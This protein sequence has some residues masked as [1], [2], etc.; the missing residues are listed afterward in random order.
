MPTFSSP[1]KNRLLAALGSLDWLRLQPFVERVDLP[2][3]QRIHQHGETVSHAYF[4]TTAVASTMHLTES[5]AC[6]ESAMVGN[7]GMLG[8]SLFM[9]G[10][11][12]FGSASVLSSGEAYRIP[13]GVLKREFNRAGTTMQVLLRYTQALLT[14]T[15]QRAICVRHHLIAQQVAVC[16]LQHADRSGRAEVF[17]TQEQIALRLGVRRE[18]VNDGAA[19]LQRLGLIRYARG[20]VEVLDREG[21]EQQACECYA[22][23][24]DEYQ[25]LLPTP[26]QPCMEAVA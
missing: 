15:A 6:A 4:F 21:L 26:C 18:G 20:H 5:G 2:R 10:G 11:P 25:R 23:Q 8:V 17:M 19:L 22:V 9:G 14:Q 12:A 7:D 24:R 16:L 13:A 3:N 1:F